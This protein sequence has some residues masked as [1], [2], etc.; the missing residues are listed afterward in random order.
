MPTLDT[1]RSRLAD[2]R[3]SVVARKT[4][5]PPSRLYRFLRGANPS[6]DTVV[7]LARYLEGRADG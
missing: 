6:G 3:V 7:R 2:R 4:G 5:I 1:L